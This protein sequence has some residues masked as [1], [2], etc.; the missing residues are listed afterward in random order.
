MQ[1]WMSPADWQRFAQM[2]EPPTTGTDLQRHLLW[3]AWAMAGFPSFARMPCP[4][5]A[6]SLERW[7]KAVLGQLPFLSPTCRECGLFLLSFSRVDGR[8]VAR[9]RSE[10]GLTVA[11]LNMDTAHREGICRIVRH[12]RLW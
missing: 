11:L 6:G 2:A 1:N 5:L 10:G 3:N 7:I 4:L 8:R 9:L 12:P